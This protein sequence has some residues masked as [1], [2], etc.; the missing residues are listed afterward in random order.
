MSDLEKALLKQLRLQAGQRD[1]LGFIKWMV[2]HFIAKNR[3]TLPWACEV[4]GLPADADFEQ[5]YKALRN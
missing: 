5:I 1:L 4:C 2:D 3:G